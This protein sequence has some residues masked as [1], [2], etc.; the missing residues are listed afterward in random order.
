MTLSPKQFLE[1]LIKEGAIDQP[2]AD[3]YEIESL[4]KNKPIDVY[5]LEETDVKKELVLQIKAELLN[6]PFID[7][8]TA[9]IDPQALSMIPESIARRN[10]IVPYYY[11]QKDEEIFIA[12]AD[13]FNLN[14]ADFLEKKT[15]KRIILS[16]AYLDDIMKSISISY[17]QG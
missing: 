12:T 6:V 13:P 3:K 9:A 5:L 14:L 8:A 15:S 2:T 10:M 17:T 7:I 16:L 1:K 4:Q 11:N